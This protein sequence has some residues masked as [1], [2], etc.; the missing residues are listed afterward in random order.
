MVGVVGFE[1]TTL[2]SQSRCANQT[3]LHPEFWC[4]V[5][6]SNCQPRITKPMLYHLTN[7]ANFSGGEC[8]SR[9]HSTAHHHRRISNP[10]PYH[11]AHSPFVWLPDVDSNH[12]SRINSPLPSPR[13]LSGNKTFFCDYIAETNMC[14][15]ISW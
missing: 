15:L 2:C 4:P 8:G 5:T 11:P 12:A 3:A 9:T 13:L 6:E 1:L 7:R 14:Q 10:M